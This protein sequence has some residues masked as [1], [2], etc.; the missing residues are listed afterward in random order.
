MN[1]TND[2]NHMNDMNGMNRMNHMNRM[3][4][5]NHMNIQMIEISK[6]QL[7]HIFNGGIPTAGATD[8]NHKDQRQTL[9]RGAGRDVWIGGSIKLDLLNTIVV[10]KFTVHPSPFGSRMG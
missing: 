4:R 5:M 10:W 7:N 1:D 3:N 6:L 2:M 9:S 8:H